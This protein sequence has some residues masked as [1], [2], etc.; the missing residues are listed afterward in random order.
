MYAWGA[1][2]AEAMAKSKSILMLIGDYVEDY[3]VSASFISTSNSYSLLFQL[4]IN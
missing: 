4:G 3:E 1:L 2:G